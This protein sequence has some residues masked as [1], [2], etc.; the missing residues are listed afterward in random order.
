MTE[1]EW[2]FIGFIFGFLMAMFCLWIGV[3]AGD[4][5]IRNKDIEKKDEK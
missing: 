2:V 3:F 1:F 4:K 5:G